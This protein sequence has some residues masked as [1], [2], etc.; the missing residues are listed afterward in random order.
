MPDNLQNHTVGIRLMFKYALCKPSK[1]QTIYKITSTCLIHCCNTSFHMLSNIFLFHGHE[2]YMAIF[3]PISGFKCRTLYS[4]VFSRGDLNF[5]VHSTPSM[6]WRTLSVTAVILRASY[7]RTVIY[8]RWRIWESPW[9]PDDHTFRYCDLISV[10]KTKHQIEMAGYRD[11]V[12]EDNSCSR[13]LTS[14]IYK[15]W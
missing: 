2:T 1:C 14:V 13:G 8:D 10:Q 12:L 4:F 3:W 11:I 6:E 5:C 15:F 7:A 9:H